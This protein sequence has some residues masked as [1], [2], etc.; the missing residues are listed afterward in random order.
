MAVE[1]SAMKQVAYVARVG[2]YMAEQLV[3][4]DESAADRRTT[5]HGRAW[6]I[7]G[8]RALRKAFFVIGKR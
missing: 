5:Y 1:R 8:Q 4:V 2:M 7:W 3:C 6:A